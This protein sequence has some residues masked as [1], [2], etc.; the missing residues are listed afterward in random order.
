MP[1]LRNVREEEAEGP[2]AELFEAERRAWGYLPNLATTLG[3]RPA[4]YR[5]WRS[6][7]GALKATMP[8]RR[9]ELATLAAAAELHST[10]CCLAHGV[11][12]ARLMPE[13][14]VMA[15]VQ[16]PAAL[17]PA[18]RAVVDLARRMV[19]D[20]TSV[21]AE[22]L[23][24]LRAFGLTDEE[25]YDVILA[26]AA[27]CFFSTMLDATGTQADEAFGELPAPLRDVLTVGRP[28]G[29]APMAR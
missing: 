28:I 27:R 14:Q 6:L 23:D 1:Y 26:V 9:Y 4:V 21:R 15:V 19:R 5:A 10:Y 25:I 3:I 16:D 7:N 20:A 18:D 12:L 11:A 8:A 29:G 24:A 13:E 17:E 22:D 2:L